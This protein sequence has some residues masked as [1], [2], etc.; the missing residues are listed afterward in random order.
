MLLQPRILNIPRKD[1]K[2]VTVDGPMPDFP[3]REREGSKTEFAL[4]S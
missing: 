1:A 2:A 4:R 3:S